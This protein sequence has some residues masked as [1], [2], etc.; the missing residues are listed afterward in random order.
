[1][2]IT[3][4]K[5]VKN[6]LIMT[7][8]IIITVIAMANFQPVTFKLIFFSFE[9]PLIILLFMLL[10]IGFSAGYLTKGYIDYRKNR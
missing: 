8:V 5:K 1:M 7:L 10:I 9:I 2:I 4:F 6:F 3:M